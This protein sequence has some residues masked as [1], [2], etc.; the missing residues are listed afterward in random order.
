MKEVTEKVQKAAI[1]AV[2]R[3]IF[4][5]AGT[6]IVLAIVMI[7]FAMALKQ[8]DFPTREYFMAHAEA[9]R[10]DILGVT[11]E[12]EARITELERRIAE[13]EKRVENLETIAHPRS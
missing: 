7:T 13:L 1:N 11:P 4:A 12:T 2:P 8:A 5:V 3:F 9:Y 6:G 10:M